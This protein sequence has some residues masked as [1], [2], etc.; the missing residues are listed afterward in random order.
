VYGGRRGK[1]QANPFR[2]NRQQ[3]EAFAALKKVMKQK[4]LRSPFKKTGPD[5][6]NITPRQEKIRR[7]VLLRT[8]QG[9]FSNPKAWQ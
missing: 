5:L 2:D 9:P 3:L 8:G 6:K 1:E 4:G 7:E